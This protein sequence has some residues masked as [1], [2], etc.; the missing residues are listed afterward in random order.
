[1]AAFDADEHIA[2][3]EQDVGFKISA[4]ATKHQFDSAKVK[5]ENWGKLSQGKY[6]LT[7]FAEIHAVLFGLVAFTVAAKQL[8][9]EPSKDT[10]KALTMKLVD[11]LPKT[12]NDAH[13][14]TQSCFINKLHQLLFAIHS[15]A[16]RRATLLADGVDITAIPD[17]D[18]N[19]ESDEREIHVHVIEIG[20]VAD[21]QHADDF[22]WGVQHVLMLCVCIFSLLSIATTMYG[23]YAGMELQQLWQEYSPDE[24]DADCNGNY[25][26]FTDNN[27][28]YG[29]HFD[30][31]VLVGIILAGVFCA[32]AL[33]LCVA[34][35]YSGKWSVKWAAYFVSFQV[36]FAFAWL[37]M[38]IALLQ[39]YNRVH[40]F[41]DEGTLIYDRTM[42][43]FDWFYS[44]VIWEIVK[45]SILLCLYC[46]FCFWARMR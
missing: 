43:I 7:S 45:N 40:E 17:Q 16:Q 46:V 19:A 12:D 13:V 25:E 21:D 42:Q 37:V 2:L 3:F 6:E 44:I 34:S 11:K 18:D 29:R 22:E 38:F 14:L 4:L 20:A 9:N 31:I 15:D 30:G 41:C 8:P 26:E 5:A 39:F 23:L 36:V 33:A 32:L 10:T 27:G 35:I 1:M 28:D 24:I